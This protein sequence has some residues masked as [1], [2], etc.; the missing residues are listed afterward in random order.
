MKLTFAFIFYSFVLTTRAFASETSTLLLN[1]KIQSSQLV[2]APGQEVSKPSFE[3][4]GWLTTNGSRTV[5]GAI[6]DGKTV[7]ELFYSNNLK[8]LDE[9]S[10]QYKKPWWYRSEFTLSPEQAHDSVVLHFKGINYSAHL[11]VN[12]KQIAN[13]SVLQGAYR[14]FSFDLSAYLN[15]YGK[16]AIALL[17]A[18]PNPDKDLT[19]SWVDWNPWPADLN[20]G[21]WKDAYLS[22]HQGVQVE[23]AWVETHLP[24][25]SPDQAQVKIHINVHSAQNQD[26]SGTLAVSLGEHTLREKIFI[27]ANE[28]RKFTL[29]ITVDHPRLWWPAQMG[30]PNLYRLKVKFEQESYESNVGL[31]EITS[32]LTEN[33]A[34]LFKINGKP[35][36]I[37]GGGYASD[38]FMRFEPQ[39]IDRDFKMVQELN[40]NTVRLEGMLQPEY[41]YQRADELGILVMPGW[42]CCNAF[43]FQKSWNEHTYQVAY[44][45]MRDQ[46]IDLRSHP[47]VFVFLYGSDE[48]PNEMSEALYLKAAK[49]TQWPNPILSAASNQTT[50]LNGATGVKMNGPY[51]YVGPSYWLQDKDKVGGAWGFSTEISPGAAIPPLESLKKMIAPD[52]LWPIDDDWNFHSARRTFKTIHLSV[53]GQNRRYGPSQ[54]VEEF[55]HKAQLLTYDGERA[56]F[57]AYSRN[58]YHSATGVIQWMLNNSWPSLF[59]H[60]YDYY[61]REGGGFFGAKKANEPIHIQYSYDDRSIVVVNSTYEKTNPLLA[62]INVLDLHSKTIFQQKVAVPA[63]NSDSVRSLV[64]LPQFDSITPVYFVQLNLSDETTHAEVS[65][66]FYWLSTQAEIYQWSDSTFYNTAM[67]QDADFTALEQLKN[68]EIDARLLPESNSNQGSIYIHNPSK[69]LAFFLEFKLENTKSGQEITPLLWSDQYISLLPNEGK[70]IHYRALEPSDRPTASVQVTWK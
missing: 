45:S 2:N 55:T 1:W 21:L 5:L 65:Q 30:A 40:L 19:F 42:I 49:V 22:F 61:Y 8:K 44:A 13:D 33:K 26:Q 46:L 70:T 69:T 63:M 67:P 41:F 53:E 3:T 38:L 32:E 7:E 15:P 36:L 4:Q 68:P 37:R 20:L 16:N 51:E 10:E 27:K 60:L 54:S 28:T 34:R 48:A 57:E 43:Q 18:P 6:A 64:Q 23:S 39:K 9:H 29:P 31:R 35:L 24:S 11:W 12:G 47:S 52:H 66:N 14:T 17:I 50:P 62:E 58:K 25:A 56:M 59:W